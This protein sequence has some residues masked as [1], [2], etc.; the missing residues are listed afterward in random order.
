MGGV[1]PLARTGKGGNGTGPTNKGG[2]PG[3]T[4]YG[5]LAIGLP[6]RGD[7]V[8]CLRLVIGDLAILELLPS[9]TTSPLWPRCSRTEKE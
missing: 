3:A 2:G 8:P 5:D 4:A 1:G 7:Q 6:L 9:A